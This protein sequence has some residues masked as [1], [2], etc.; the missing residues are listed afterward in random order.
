MFVLILILVIGKKFYD[1]ADSYNK[2]KWGYAIAGALSY[3]VG[4]FIL[5][6]VLG[7][8]LLVLESNF[9]ETASDFVLTIITIPVGLLSCYLFYVF[10]ERKWEKEKPDKDN[11]IDQI[12]NS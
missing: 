3:Y 2:S 1:L 12:G 8:V 11:L 5:G 4:A 9:L 6:L 10:L 7:A